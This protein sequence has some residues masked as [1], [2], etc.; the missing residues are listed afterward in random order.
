METSPKPSTRPW[1]PIN[2]TLV[3]IFLIVAFLGFADAT[4]LTVKHFL[5]SAVTCSLLNGCGPVTSSVWSQI[6]GIPVALLGSLYYLGM[7]VLAAV[8]L[9]SKNEFV[10]TWLPRL[11][12]LGLIASMYFVSLQ[13]FVIQAYCLYC[14]G[15]AVTSA[16]LFGLGVVMVLRKDRGTPKN[17]Q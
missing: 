4:Y 2:N 17:D 10:G 11:T 6:F 5:G 16:T 13:V 7:M 1:L 3:I 12:I 9:E 8:Y 15:S 14:M